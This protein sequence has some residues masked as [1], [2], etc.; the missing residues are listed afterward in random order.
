MSGNGKIEHLLG[1]L[2]TVQARLN[3]AANNR[4]ASGMGLPGGNE[5]GL[6]ELQERVKAIK[7]RHA[8][9]LS[10]RENLVQ[11]PQPPPPVSLDTS[12]RGRGK[13]LDSSR[14]AGVSIGAGARSMDRSEKGGI[15]R[16][17]SGGRHQS[18]PPRSRAQMDEEH[19]HGL[20]LP[21]IS[22]VG[23][24]K[25]DQLRPS[26]EVKKEHILTKNQSHQVTSEGPGTSNPQQNGKLPWSP[27]DTSGG[28]NPQDQAAMMA[29][30]MSQMQQMMAAQQQGQPASSAG[31]SSGVG[32]THGSFD[33]QMMQQ[34]FSQMASQW[35]GGVLVSGGPG[36]TQNN[37]S[38]KPSSPSEA[39]VSPVPQMGSRTDE[40]HALR[41]R[42]QE[43]MYQRQKSLSHEP[44]RTG[45]RR[46]EGVPMCGSRS[47]SPRPRQNKTL[48]VEHIDGQ[49]CRSRKL[50]QP[51]KPAGG[52][53]RK[54][55]SLPPE[56]PLG[57]PIELAPQAP[58]QPSSRRPSVSGGTSRAQKLAEKQGTENRLEEM[59]FA[60][61]IKPPKQEISLTPDPKA[62]MQAPPTPY[63][64]MKAALTSAEAQKS[65]LGIFQH[66]FMTR[67][68]RLLARSWRQW[69]VNSGLPLLS[70]RAPKKVVKAKNAVG[71]V[72]Q[73]SKSK[74]LGSSEP[75]AQFST[76][77]HDP[78]KCK[79]ATSNRQGSFVLHAKKVAESNSPKGPGL[80][81]VADD[82]MYAQRHLWG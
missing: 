10:V 18:T 13:D 9:R 50:L 42:P 41:G 61:S 12:K 37:Q 60:L 78:G 53:I 4:R 46:D 2:E 40:A 43:G 55:N 67:N 77:V 44:V 22:G 32:N 48:N 19:T 58:S 70:K 30:M 39:W 17:R 25:E 47:G 28:T 59:P 73:L 51:I 16:S 79:E 21:S 15:S 75:A 6:S 71:I 52:L 27:I 34:M 49:L 81:K 33:P 14:R 45:M 74:D 68:A 5:A 64:E 63:K 57:A 23:N 20:L 54:D 29:Q 8:A 80:A 56:R 7:E 35:A 11:K 1:R 65:A 26:A 72:H 76:G 82:A 62:L 3:H 31:L 66:F 24:G 69:R 36:A 38:V